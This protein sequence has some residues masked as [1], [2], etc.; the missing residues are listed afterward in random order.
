[1]G[2]QV[3][4]LL[5][6]VEVDPKATHLVFH[7]GDGVYDDS[8]TMEEAMRDDTLLADAIG[9]APLDPDGGRP[10]RLVLP[11][12]WGYKYVKWVVRIEAIAAEEYSGYWEDRGYP[13][14]ATIP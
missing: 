3:S 2:V 1:M 14:D 11:G 8:L 12:S 10:L 6:L 13:A 9:G 4:Q 7:S 5:K